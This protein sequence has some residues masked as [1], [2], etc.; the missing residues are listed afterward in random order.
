MCLKVGQSLVRGCLEVG[1]P[2]N[3]EKFL[4]SGTDARNSNRLLDGNSR[5]SNAAG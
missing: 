5:D 2:L 4:E 1:Y 3:F